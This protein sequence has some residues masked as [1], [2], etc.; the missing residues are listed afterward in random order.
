MLNHLWVWRCLQTICQ[1]YWRQ[2][3]RRELLGLSEQLLADIG[4][5]RG[6]ALWEG[7]KPFW[8]Q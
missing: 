7:S 4:R 1:A 2:R 6:E 5:S 8:K 3:A